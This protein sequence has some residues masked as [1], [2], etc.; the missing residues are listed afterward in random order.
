M[1]SWLKRHTTYGFRRAIN[2]LLEGGR[3]MRRHR[4]GLRRVRKL[5][6]PPDARVQLGSG[7]HPK[8]G[9]INIDLYAIEGTD[10]ALDLREDLPF[11]DNSIALIYTEHLF[12]HLDY[13]RDARHLLR[14]ALRVLKPGGTFSIVIPHFGD[15]LH[16]YA[17]G[18]REFFTAV[19]L[20]LHEGEPT[21]MHHVNYWFRQDGLHRYAYDEETLG[22]VMSEVG[23]ELVRSREFDPRLDSEQR[24]RLHSLYMEGHKPVAESVRPARASAGL[25][26]PVGSLADPALGASSGAGYPKTDH[27]NRRQI[28]PYS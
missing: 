13:P 4:Q 2:A 5:R 16:A 26:E 27:V 11:P 19:R 20:H 21:L 17:R 12:E 25:E 22:Q 7:R 1:T 3:V 18:D 8:P 24:H 23:F 15:L 14:E 10:L 28:I 6:I 9:W